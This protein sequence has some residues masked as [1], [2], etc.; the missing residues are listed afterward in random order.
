MTETMPAVGTPGPLGILACAG[1][2]PLE[3]ADAAQRQGRSVHIVAIEGFASGDVARFPHERVKLG[4]L[5]QLLASFERAGA[6]ELVIAGAMQRPD[7]LGLRI[8]WGFVRNLGTILSLTRGGDDSV[9]RR[10][11]RFFEGQG[12]RVVGAGD[13]APGLLAPE[14]MLGG[15]PP[16][17]QHEAAIEQAARLI[18]MLGPFDVGQAAVATDR[19]I[20]AVEGA[21]GTDAMLGDL[22]P[23]GLGAGLGQGGVLVKLAKPDQEMRIDL[24]TIGPETVR[25][26]AAAGLAGIAVGAGRTI[27]LER[28]RVIEATDAAGLFVA[29][30]ADAATPITGGT[31]AIQPMSA[32]GI[33]GR[34]APTPADRRDIAIGRSLMS[35]LEAEGAGNAALVSREHVLAISGAMPLATFLQAQGRPASWGR[36]TLRGR[37]GVLLLRPDAKSAAH[38]AG[39][40]ELDADLF[41]A[42]LQAGIAGLVV[43]GSLPAGPR[44]AEIEGWAGEAGLFLMAEEGGSGDRIP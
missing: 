3:V 23:G 37:L 1:P 17:S 40:S 31:S 15:Q 39:M 42:A 19:G 11:I 29:G 21:R 13:V 20:V 14:G 9:L 41:R 36:R 2:L 32:L 6:R 26:A 12:F 5:G 18:R 30:L 24:P 22:G 35:R 10:V 34:R 25:R 16:S 43:L 28:A 27:V 7:L 8:D 4:Q 44:R 33:F 38:V